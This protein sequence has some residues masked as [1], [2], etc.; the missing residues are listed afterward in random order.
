MTDISE[1]QNLLQKIHT[2]E[3]PEQINSIQKNLELVYIPENTH[4]PNLCFR[5]AE[6]VRDEYKTHFS[7]LDLAYFLVGIDFKGG[8]NGEK[9]VFPKSTEEFWSFVKKG[10]EK[11]SS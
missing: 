4:T 7:S 6:D 5:E 1:F 8:N 2:G 10:I 11:V 9:E 3:F